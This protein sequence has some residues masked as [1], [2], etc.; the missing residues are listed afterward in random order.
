MTKSIGKTPL[1]LPL[2]IPLINYIMLMQ[3]I[4]YLSGI[5]GGSNAVLETFRSPARARFQKD[6]ELFIARSLLVDTPQ[7]PLAL[8]FLLSRSESGLGQN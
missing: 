6:L 1:K 5:K 3:Y 8:R 2:E 7:A 4:L